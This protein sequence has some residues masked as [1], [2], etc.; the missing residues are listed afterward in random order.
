M[1]EN[2]DRQDHRFFHLALGQCRNPQ[3]GGR[4]GRNSLGERLSHA[5]LEMASLARHPFFNL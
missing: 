5:N 1:L 4:M 2:Q 3:G